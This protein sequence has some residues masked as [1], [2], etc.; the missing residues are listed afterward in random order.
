MLEHARALAS[1]RLPAGDIANVIKLGLKAFIREAEKQR[2]AA[3]RKPRRKVEA[4]TLESRPPGGR[5]DSG[6]PK[7]TR[8]VPAA[9]AREVYE[10]DRGECSFISADGQRCACRVFLELD[11]IKPWA[12]GGAATAANLRLRCKPHNQSHARA[13]FGEEKIARAIALNGAIRL[14]SASLRSANRR[15]F[16]G[17]LAAQPSLRSER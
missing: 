13:Y 16:G 9:V 4:R 15:W 8:H 11:H 1:H 2:F 6:T 12:A 3:G 14:P 10:R 7:R 5:V 17:C